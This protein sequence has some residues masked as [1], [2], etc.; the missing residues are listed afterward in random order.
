MTNGFATLRHG[1]EPATHK[2]RSASARPRPD[3]TGTRS[4]RANRSV[5]GDQLNGDSDS[6][7]GS[8]LGY[9]RHASSSISLHARPRIAR[10]P[11]RL[12]DVCAVTDKSGIRLAI[13]AAAPYGGKTLRKRKVTAAFIGSA[14][15]P[16]C[17]IGIVARTGIFY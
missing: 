2:A 13:A 8:E 16:H 15:A 9:R 5:S 14:A 11:E 7:R 6:N 3:S 12:I 10:A 4:P 17:A 1:G